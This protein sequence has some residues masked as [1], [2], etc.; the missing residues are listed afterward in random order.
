MVSISACTS[1]FALSI[2]S[3]LIAHLKSYPALFSDVP[4]HIPLIEYDVDVGDAAVSSDKQ[5]HLD[6]EV[7]YVSRIAEPCSSSWSTTCL[8]VSKLDKTDRPCTDFGKVN[9]ITKPDVLPL[10]CMEDCI[11]QVGSA[12]H[13]SKFDLL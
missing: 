12:T 10:P 5:R 6:Q 4:S 1:A 2:S 3:H 13:V 7:Q 9:N 8:L 11:D